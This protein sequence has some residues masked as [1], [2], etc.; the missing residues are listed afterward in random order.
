[1]TVLVTGGAGYIGSHVVRLLDQRGDDVVILD[2]MSNGVRSRAEGRPLIELDLASPSAAEIL[3]EKMNEHGIDSVIHFAAK[4][5]VG[6]SHRLPLW[7]YQQ[8]VGGLMNL[9]QAME[10]S[11]A[12]KLVFS[13]SATVYGMPDVELIPE[14]CALQP[15]NP[16]GQTKVAGE[17]LIDAQAS[18]D[19]LTAV[20]LRYFN[21][22]GTGWQDLADTAVSNLIPIVLDRY[23]QGQRP[24]VFGSDY[25]TADGTC[26]RDYIHVLDLAEAHISALDYLRAG[27]VAQTSFNVGTGVGSSV[28]DVI[29]S[30]SRVLGADLSPVIADRRAGD[31]PRLVADPSAAAVEL[32][33]KA[34]HS[35]DDCVRSAVEGQTL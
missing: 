11:G 14:E 31:A 9:L 5:S 23:R 6:E 2:D 20:K 26:I 27:Q 13:S 19:K 8:N 32:A 33:W 29:D 18:A 16:Y 24:V 34:Q 35:L 25:D 1:M 7:Y 21:V 17:W 10:A 12:D 3:P 28:L 30:V 4:K 15:I 22:A